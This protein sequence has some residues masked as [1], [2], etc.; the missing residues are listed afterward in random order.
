GLTFT[1][2][3]SV[4][5]TIPGDA[6]G[7]PAASFAGKTAEP[8]TLAPLVVPPT[9]QNMTVSWSAA[10]DAN[11][12]M[13]L[14]FRFHEGSGTGLN[15]QLLCD[16]RDDGTGS[17]QAALI[18]RWVASGDRDVFA[19]RLRTAIVRVPSA[20]DAFINLVSTFDLPTPVSP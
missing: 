4:F 16:F 10:T 15:Q 12:A 9:N 6:A 5:V 18:A 8:F 13:L 14:S 1:P 11:A 17:V 2:G 3:D 20:T 7:F 19:E